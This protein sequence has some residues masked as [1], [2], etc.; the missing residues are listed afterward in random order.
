MAMEWTVEQRQ[1][2]EA[3]HSNLI[4][5]AAAGSGKTAVL[6]ERICSLVMSEGVDV[7]RMLVATFTRAAAAEMRSRIVERLTH[8]AAADMTQSRRLNEQL[9]KIDRAPIGTLHSFCGDLLRQYYNFVGIEPSF[10]T[11]D[12][13]ITAGIFDEALDESIDTFFEAGD[14]DFML[15]ADCWGGRDGDGLKQLVKRVYNAARNYPNYLL[16]L[17]DKVQLFNFTDGT[18]TPWYGELRS[19]LTSC[20][21]LAI[22]SLDEAVKTASLPCAPQSYLPQ[23][24]EDRSALL[25]L[26]NLA[27]TGNMIALSVSLNN[28]ALFGR[29]PSWKDTLKSGLGERVKES[30]EE[31]KKLIKKARENPL[32]CG[33]EEAVERTKAMFPQMN[34]LYSL[35][36]AFDSRYSEQK[37]YANVLDFSDLEHMALAVLADDDA[38]EEIQD[39][40]DYVFV[41][42]YQDISPIQDELL[43]QVSKPGSFFC[44]GDVKQSI[45]RFRSAE[46][47]IFINRLDDSIRTDDVAERRIDLNRNFRSAGRVISL[48]NYLF[49]NLMSRSLG[50]VEYAG[51]ESLVLAAPQPAVTIKESSNELILID[52]G[53][54]KE[55]ELTRLEELIQIEREATVVA[56][57][58]M[59]MVGK[60]LWDGKSGTFRKLR[61]QDI[62]IVLR[63]VSSVASDYAEVFR[64]SGIPVYAEAE[65]GFIGEL[66]IQLLM[67]LLRL[68]DNAYRDYELITSMHSSIGRFTLEDLLEIR[69]L[70]PTGSFAEAVY[71][72]AKEFNT[73]LAEKINVFLA[74]LSR[75]RA[76][77]RHSDIEK[78]IFQICDETGF[79]DYAGTLPQGEHRQANIAHLGSLARGF[80][81]G[82]YDFIRSFDTLAASGSRTSPSGRPSGAVTIMSVHK[83]KGL[84]FPVV[85]LSNVGK[86]INF[87][88]T[89]E[90]MLTH[91][92]LGLGPRYF[93][94][95]KRTRG[96]TLA[97][98]ALSERIRQDT[99]SEE[100]RML[101]VA[102]TRAREQLI[103]VGTVADLEGKLNKWALPI[104]AAGLSSRARCWADWLGPMA[105]RTAQGCEAFAKYG[106]DAG[107]LADSPDDWKVTVLD[108]GNIHSLRP[109]RFD[110]SAAL[111]QLMQTVES[112]TVPEDM[113]SVLGWQYPWG[114]VAALPSKVS[115]TS[116][117]D[118]QRN[119]RGPIPAPEI[120]RLPRFMEEKKSFSATDL[121]TFVHTALQLLPADV[122]IDEIPEQ[123]IRLEQRGLLPEGAVKAINMDWIVRF[124]RSDIATRMRNSVQVQRELP[125]NLA[126]P[127]H[128]VYAG[129]TS[130]EEILVQGIIDCCFIED[131]KWILLYYKTNRVDSKNTAVK[132]A[133]YYKPQLQ[134]YRSALEEITGIEVKEAYLY[135]LSVGEEARV[136]L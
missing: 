107:L 121:G 135:L 16:W 82:L 132:I 128:V 57:K 55:E 119:W 79:Y 10:K 17:R 90:S 35:I 40:F 33:F 70:H 129:E 8:S 34:A 11:E 37:R 12:E 5:S 124:F 52:N 96:D 115:A 41:D 20:I 7:E 28:Q 48:A 118:K 130:G 53:G 136:K 89:N 29:L 2:I 75:W 92:T 104:T 98:A 114:D 112:T 14:C 63:T 97:R 27:D 18:D 46:P 56:H 105:L 32:V 30:R 120:R 76:L 78:L 58:I 64:R 123:V 59:E 67:N 122:A 71:L 102:V 31:A 9:Q 109:E 68:I 126:I 3:R 44:V 50:G 101:Y 99:L 74:S 38:R 13:S 15:L 66:E 94:A 25:Q 39:S 85:I 69:G 36:I 77:S 127:A 51:S 6:V 108:A 72:Y 103:I 117:L 81:G 62:T 116:L 110:K 43:R 22:E 60:P 26:L 54:R 24:T 131:D 93:N 4:V 65:G 42:E 49:T 125:F 113:A 95:T 47:A 61:Y 73:E 84:E 88:D 83:S 91:G 86:P 87:M 80:T 21:A 106:V 133:E 23:L 19:K 100:M 1:V 45:Y 111:A 134:T